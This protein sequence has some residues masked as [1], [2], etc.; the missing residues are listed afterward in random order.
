[1]DEST[2]RTQ[3][4]RERIYGRSHGPDL[5]YARDLLDLERL[6]AEA[7]PGMAGSMALRNLTSRYPIEADA[8]VRELGVR[9]FA[10]FEEG[11][12]EAL[13]EE[14]LRLAERRH[15]LRR[16]SPDPLGLLEG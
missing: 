3:F 4:V 14:R 8:I 16:L 10:P 13:M 1:M 6:L 12:L 11:R 2:P 7:P 9:P 5:P 15:P